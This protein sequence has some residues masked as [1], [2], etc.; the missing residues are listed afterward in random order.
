VAKSYGSDRKPAP[1]RTRVLF[2]AWGYSVHAERGIRPFAEDPE[3]E[4][5]VVSNHDY[6]F[7]GAQ[8][9]PLTDKAG[10]KALVDGLLT[11]E[12]EEAEARQ[13]LGLAFRARRSGERAARAVRI[14][15]LLARFGIRDVALL[16]RVV[17]SMELV[18][19]MELALRDGGILLRAAKEF[20][21]EVVFLQ[22]LLYPCYLAAL[23]S[24]RVPQ[25]V[26][27][28][29]GDATWWD[30]WTGTDRLMKKAI[31]TTCARRAT[32]ITV[33]SRAVLEACRGY[34][35][36]EGRVHLVRYP[37][38]D[39]TRFT[40]LPREEARRALGIRERR[41]VLC[42]RGLGGY[43]NSDVIVEASPAVLARHP[44]TL[45]LFV[46]GVGRETELEGHRSRA[47]GLGTAERF[48]WEGQVPPEAMPL[49]YGAADVMVSVSSRDSLPN[50]M[51]EAMACA[52]P[53]VMG[54]I[55][56]IREWVEDGVTGF[57]VPPRSPEALAARIA[58]VFES[59]SLRLDAVARGNLERVRWE[60]DS[61]RNAARVKEI[62]RQ[63]AGA[64]PAGT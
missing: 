14:A 24:R 34:G 29:N 31:V 4:V 43:L 62:V 49:Y 10:K 2:L 11:R 32:A 35:I 12:R 21:P 55:P 1:R 16:R 22:T 18:Y 38:T 53:V 17:N 13:A 26:S 54:D 42:P 58:E 39:L 8:N 28:W 63:V 46:S 44:D 5:A 7:A 19:E 64:F 41:V 25:V 52:V 47:R 27:F 59:P 61:G 56:A 45:F 60:A 51:L 20:R 9:I 37:Q 40:P 15:R 36:P 23:L 57:L 48:R 50:C 33:N 3:F 30:E 6:A